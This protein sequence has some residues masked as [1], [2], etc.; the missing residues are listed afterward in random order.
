MTGVALPAEGVVLEARSPV[1]DA[2][3]QLDDPAYYPYQRQ[4]L[5]VAL[6]IA[7]GWHIYGP[8]VPDGYTPL[9]VTV[10][11]DPAGAVIEPID[12]PTTTPIVVAGLDE[13]FEAYG[14]RLDLVAPFE[15]IVPRGTGDV[16]L[17]V[18]IDLQACSDVEC[19]PP[20]FIEVSTVVPERAVP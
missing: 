11:S 13:R 2:A 10:S 17:D 3:V 19:M 5:H 8:V 14:G 4:R 7:E 9:R 6:T 18:R 16:R 12:W 20:R 1:V 15:V